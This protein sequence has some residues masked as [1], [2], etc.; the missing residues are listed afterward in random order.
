MLR[1]IIRWFISVIALLV[2][3]HIFSGVTT[4]NLSSLLVMALVLGFLN[5]FLKPILSIFSLPIMILT[6]GLFTLVINAT[7]F[8]LAAKLVHGIHVAGFGSAFW[9]AF[10]YSCITFLLNVFLFPENKT[11]YVRH[12]TITYK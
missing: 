5:A 10:L 3:V 1:F 9:A 4:D 6:L 7:T 2:I 11:Y 8:Y 12:T